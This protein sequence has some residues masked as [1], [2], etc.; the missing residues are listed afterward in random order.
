MVYGTMGGTTGF[1]TNQ[2]QLTEDNDGVFASSY[3]KGVIDLTHILSRA[4]GKQLSQMATYRVSHLSIQLRNVDDAADNDSAATFGGNIRW[5]P[6]TRHRIDA[7]QLARLY[8]RSYHSGLMSSD[9]YAEFSSDKTYK[10]L[11]FNWDADGQIE[12]ASDDH[13]STL[14]GTGFSMG[15]IFNAYN[16]MISGT[17]TGEGYNS[18]GQG[19]A[20]WEKRCGDPITNGLQWVTSFKNR[21]VTNGGAVFNDYEMFDPVSRTWT[22]TAPQGQ[23]VPVL[24]GL[25]LLNLTHGNTDAPNVVEDEYELLVTV[26]VEGWEEF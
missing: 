20:L 6:P 18:T 25:L 4:L 11:R 21:M 8:N 15:Q 17:P 3:A 24:G 7:L 1:Y 22:W 10:G 12:E 14:S 13:T 23:S 5:Y 2:Q 26:G 19:Q 16:N 9:P